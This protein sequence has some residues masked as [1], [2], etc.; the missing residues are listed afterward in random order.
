MGQSTT[1]SQSGDQPAQSS[2]A[3]GSRRSILY[4]IIGIIIVVVILLIVASSIPTGPSISIQNHSANGTRLYMNVSQAQEL[5]GST[6]SNYSVSDL[7]N[8][9]ALI[10]MSSLI[11]IVPQLYGNATS[12]W[13]T[14]AQGSNSSVNA[15]IEFLEITTNNTSSIAGDLGSYFV[16]TLNISPTTVNTGTLNG[17]NYTYGL[18]KNSSTSFQLLY[19]SKNHD[20]VIALVQANQPFT[21]N[22]TLLISYSASDTP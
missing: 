2:P 4:I 16:S 19:G 8:P 5:L 18:Y 6:V 1:S 17:L 15:S 20:A 10:N 7:F 11:T 12:G 21:V 22:E 13:V 14:T 3:Q 9:T